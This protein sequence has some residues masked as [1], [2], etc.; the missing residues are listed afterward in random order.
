MIDSA[1]AGSESW[2]IQ[3]GPRSCALDYQAKM[4]RVARPESSKGVLASTT[5]FED[6][7]HATL[8][9]QSVEACVPMRSMG[10]RGKLA[11][12]RHNASTTGF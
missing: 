10:T 3:H 1:G 9:T 5:P 4:N 12:C 6:S 7:R 11:T 2:G 8:P